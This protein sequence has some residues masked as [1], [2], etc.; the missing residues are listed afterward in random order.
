MTGKS[1]KM[2]KKSLDYQQ[3]FAIED[4]DDFDIDVDENWSGTVW[5]YTIL[6]PF[7]D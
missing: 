7:C 6:T 5:Q 1:Q 3:P 4:E 2:G